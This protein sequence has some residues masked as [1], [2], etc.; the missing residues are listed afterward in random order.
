V[1]DLY[2]AIR[3]D[4]DLSL[5]NGTFPILFNHRMHI[6]ESDELLRDYLELH[7]IINGESSNIPHFYLFQCSQRFESHYLNYQ[8]QSKKEIFHVDE[9]WKPSSCEKQTDDAMSIYLLSLYSLTLLF[10]TN[11]DTDLNHLNVTHSSH[12]LAVLR[13]ILFP[14]ACLALRHLIEGALFVFEKQLLSEALYQ[15][16]RKCLPQTIPNN[17][18]FLYTPHILYANFQKTQV[19]PKERDGYEQIILCKLCEAGDTQ[20]VSHIYFDNPVMKFIDS[21]EKFSL[22]E[23]EDEPTETKDTYVKQ[24]DL[25]VIMKWFEN[26]SEKLMFSKIT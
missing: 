20:H 26:C 21:N 5:F 12:F 2:Q 6:L 23:L 25:K 17:Q 15:L 16:F 9:V 4:S 7:N 14:P 13:Q 10:G 11:L 19:T 24:T 18:V 8:N 3:V 22:M 1:R